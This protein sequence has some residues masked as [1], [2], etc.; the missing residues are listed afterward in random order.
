MKNKLKPTK[1]D[2]I[3]REAR[4]KAVVLA[5]GIDDY[6]ESVGF[7]RLKTCS[8]DAQAVYN[9]FQDVWQLN[10]DND[11]SVLLTSKSKS[12]PS[13]GHIIRTLQR[14]TG[15][16]DEEDL[17][18]FYYSGHGHKLDGTDDLLLV[19]QDAYD[20]Q[21]QDAFVPFSMI[22]DELEKSPAKNK[23]IILD[24]CLS[25][26]NVGRKIVPSRVS[27]KLLK[28][29]L[30]DTQGLAIISSSAHD[31]PSHTKSPN[32]GLSLFTY[33]LDRALNGQ[34]EALRDG[35]LTLTSLMEYIS[36]EVTKKAREYGYKQ[37]PSFE[38]S[39]TGLL[40][41]A[42][43]NESLLPAS[44]FEL[45]TQPIRNIEYLERSPFLVKEVLT[46]IQNWNYSQEYLADLVNRGI[47][48]HFEDDFGEYVASLMNDIGLDLESITVNDNAILF[49]GGHYSVEYEPI[50][51]RKGTVRFSL[52]LEHSWFESPDQLPALLNCFRLRPDKL[53]VHL[54]TLINPHK[55]IPGL[56]AKDWTIGSVK[57]EQLIVSHGRY[58][59]TIEQSSLTLAGFTLR[60]L[61]ADPE[62]EDTLLLSGLF[63]LLS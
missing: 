49:P 62:S 4:G 46:Q 20:D 63:Q 12:K 34:K 6:D 37:I 41:F 22:R 17:L 29:Y 60:E 48:Q 54:S 8:A 25:G 2:L 11:R 1:T 59:V 24:A 13:R 47:P 61:F 44:D 45:A 52:I 35:Y 3:I 31:Q 33:Y 5:I 32:P 19:P 14:F 39:S 36:T 40:Y 16:I 53:T 28:E 43:F 38:T 9:A 7:P 42:N 18:I 10:C 56:R 58:T 51:K 26:P 55:L 23:L 21:D 50:E 30:K 57:N 15:R 27:A